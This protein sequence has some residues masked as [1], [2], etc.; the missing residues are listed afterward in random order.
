MHLKILFQRLTTNDQRLTT[1]K[2]TISC[3]IHDL[4]VKLRGSKRASLEELVINNK[5][6]RLKCGGWKPGVGC[7][8][9]EGSAFC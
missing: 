5:G 8:R 1:Y 3:V 7:L 9:D 2:T 4:E 6:G